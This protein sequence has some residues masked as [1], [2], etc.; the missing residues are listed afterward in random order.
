MSLVGAVRIDWLLI[1]RFIQDGFVVL[2]LTRSP[3]DYSAKSGLHFR[4]CDAWTP[5]SNDYGGPFDCTFG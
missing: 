5:G 4:V 3:D 2:V 1:S